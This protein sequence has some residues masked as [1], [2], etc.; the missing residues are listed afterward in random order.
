LSEGLR[1][2]R[3]WRQVE[4]PALVVRQNG[5]G[6][7][8]FV[9]VRMNVN[10]RLLTRRYAE[11]S[12][13]ARVRVERDAIVE[14]QG[15]SDRKLGITCLDPYGERHGVIGVNERRCSR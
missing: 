15:T 5:G 12:L 1:L 9:S 3:L 14:Y 8:R 11:G 13:T 7:H 6:G 4:G 10:G 2:V